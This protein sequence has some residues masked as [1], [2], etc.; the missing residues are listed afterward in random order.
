M[1]ADE[2]NSENSKGEIS[3]KVNHSKNNKGPFKTPLE[4]SKLG[5]WLW[6]PLK[7]IKKRRLM[8][9]IL[10]PRKTNTSPENQCL[11]DKKILF[12]MVPFLETYVHHFFFGGI[13]CQAA[14]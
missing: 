11:E 3:S 6:I 9:N 2:H 7:I 12:E 14:N 5:L 13:F 10:T 8:I 1:T 4:L